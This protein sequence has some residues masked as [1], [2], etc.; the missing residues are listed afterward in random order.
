MAM[1]GGAAEWIGT[2]ITF[3]LSQQDDQTIV[4]FG[5]SASVKAVSRTAGISMCRFL[6]RKEA[7][8]DTISLLG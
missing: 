3:Q 6:A 7:P 2:D 5:H 4:L 8:L 1:H